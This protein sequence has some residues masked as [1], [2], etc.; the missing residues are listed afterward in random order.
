[1]KKLILFMFLVGALSAQSIKDSG[2]ST[3]SLLDSS[4]VFTGTRKLVVDYNSVTVS[5]WSDDTATVSVQ[6]GDLVSN[7]FTIQ[8]YY[9]FTYLA[10]D[11]TFSKDF[12]IVAPYYRVVV[13]NSIDD[14]MTVFRLTS[15]LHKSFINTGD[16]ATKYWGET[17]TVTT[18]VDTFS[19]TAVEYLEGNI[20]AGDSIQVAIDGAFTAGQTWI[21]TESTRV[22]LNRWDARTS[23][24]I[25]IRRYG[26]AGTPR[27]Y[28]RL[29]GR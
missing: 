4:D 27:Y 15:M 12:P 19:T 1:M 29:S 2:N 14:S 7:T 21:I 13:T 11:T 9:N 26:S 6:F 20:I 22:E 8:R 5:M 10:N 24:K 25:Y 28:L 17:D 16:Y 23:N 18:R 3:T